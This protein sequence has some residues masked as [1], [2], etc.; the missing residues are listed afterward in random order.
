M[1]ACIYCKNNFS[2]QKSL[3]S[4]QNKTKYCLLLQ[5]KDE[6]EYEKKIEVLQYKLEEQKSFY[7]LQIKNKDNYLKKLE[8]ELIVLQTTKT[9]H[10]QTIA[11]QQAMI[12]DLNNRI[13]N[14]AI[15]GVTKP[16]SSIKNIV[17]IQPLTDE[18]LKSTAMLLTQN[19]VTNINSLASFAI[20]NSLKNRVIASDRSRKTLVYKNQS[21]KLTKDPYG[22]CI[23]R[24]FFQSISDRD[25][26]L[27]EAYETL[28]SEM[29]KLANNL[30]QDETDVILKKANEIVKIRR[31]IKEVSS[32]REHE[33]KEEFVSLLCKLVPSKD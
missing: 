26:V 3:Y 27:D 30:S 17:N 15:Q 14:I 16:S 4:H 19:D 22:H 32:G 2:T 1:F 25:D 33:L 8:K 31:G 18:H 28:K 24:R 13:E 29:N 7:D 6:Q 5:T 20:N 10:E 23:A 21:G 11:Q 9:N 12:S